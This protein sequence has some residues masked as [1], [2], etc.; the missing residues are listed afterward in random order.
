MNPARKQ[1]P[2]APAL[3]KL[4]VSGESAG[5]PSNVQ[6]V[7]NHASESTAAANVQ[8]A[9]HDQSV[10]SSDRRP[11]GNIADIRLSESGRRSFVT[12]SGENAEVTRP[13]DGQLNKASGESVEDQQSGSE[14]SDSETSSME[15]VESEDQPA[16]DGTATAAATTGDVSNSA[17]R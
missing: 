4:D 6:R 3:P 1:K 16:T 2:R 7:D 9:D 11:D 8:R 13:S 17:D 5:A 14:S 10:R 15:V 12:G